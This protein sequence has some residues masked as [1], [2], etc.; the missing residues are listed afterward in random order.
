MQPDAQ[1]KEVIRLISEANLAQA[2][3]VCLEL[4]SSDPA[5]INLSA[6][7]GA[8]LLK[9]D[10]LGEAESILLDVTRTAPTFA[11]PHQDL[12]ILYVNRIDYLAAAL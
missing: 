1:F 11:K 2:E 5:D 10:R 8:I 3:A 12:A 6:L 9:G 4:L 7:L